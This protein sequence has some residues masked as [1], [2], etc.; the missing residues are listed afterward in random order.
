MQGSYR[1]MNKNVSACALQV[2]GSGELC[3]RGQCVFLR[4]LVGGWRTDGW[5]QWVICFEF[6]SAL[7]LLAGWQG[8]VYAVKTCPVI[9]TRSV[10][11]ILT[12]D[13]SLHEQ[14]FLKPRLHDTTRLKPVVK[15]VWQPVVSCIQ[16]FNQLSDPFDNWFDKRLYSVYSRLYNRF[17]N[18]VERTTRL[19]NRV[20]QTGCT[21]QFDNRLNEQCCSFNTVVKPVW[22]L[23]V[24][25]KRC[26]TVSR[27]DS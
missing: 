22:Q 27:K 24:S 20:C 17:D 7:T 3:W 15:P 2:I 12:L 13:N 1:K 4:E 10:L 5:G 25:C 8:G 21:T 16:T 23:V 14:V 18:G 19:S 9:P 11:W 6:S 26:F